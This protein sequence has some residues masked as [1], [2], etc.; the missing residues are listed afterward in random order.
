MRVPFLSSSNPQRS[1]IGRNPAGAL[2]AFDQQSPTNMTDSFAERIDFISS[3]C[4]RWCE[5]CAYTSRCS[6]YACQVAVAMC[7][8][9]GWAGG[10]AGRRRARSANTGVE[11]VSTCDVVCPAGIRRAGAIDGGDFLGRVEQEAYDRER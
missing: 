9:R 6:T 3:Y 2:V 7:G 8:D 1:F 11:G 10:S 4:D 5:R